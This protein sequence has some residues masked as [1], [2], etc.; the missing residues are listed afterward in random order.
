MP[1]S[2]TIREFD[3]ARHIEVEERDGLVFL[4]I[5]GGCYAFDRGIFMHGIRK[6]LQLTCVLQG[7]TVKELEK[8]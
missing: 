3:A 1:G 5:D 7:L 2:V 4:E 8:C 6:A